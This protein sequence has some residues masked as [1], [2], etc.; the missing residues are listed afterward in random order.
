MKRILVMLLLT[1]CMARVGCAE[2]NDFSGY[3]DEQLSELQTLG[4]GEDDNEGW[5]QSD[6]GIVKVRAVSLEQDSYPTFVLT[7]EV[8]CD[9]MK[10]TTKDWWDLTSRLTQYTAENKQYA[11]RKVKLKIGEMREFKH[12][13]GTQYEFLLQAL[14]PNEEPITL[15]RNDSFDL[16]RIFP[17]EF[18]NYDV[19]NCAKF[20]NEVKK[21]LFNPESMIIKDAKVY[22]PEKEGIKYY[23]FTITG[24]NRMGGNTTGLYIARLNEKTGGYDVV[25]IGTSRYDSPEFIVNNSGIDNSCLSV[26][27]ECPDEEKGIELNEYDIVDSM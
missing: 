12:T 14:G 8:E 10:T 7:Y 18:I 3:S 16:A 2:K 6:D 9:G 1:V 25:E 5:F 11:N 22:V 20:A 15:L 24:Q 4:T 26:I 17:N 21:L 19:K 13:I 27:I 23:T